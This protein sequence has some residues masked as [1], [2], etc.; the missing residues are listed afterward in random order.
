M[1]KGR[2]YTV[3][4]FHWTLQKA[5]CAVLDGETKLGKIPLIK[6]I[7]EKVTKV[8]H[9]FHYVNTQEKYNFKRWT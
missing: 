2:L 6:L 5:K 9:L 4:F 3:C 1:V 8:Q 7:Q